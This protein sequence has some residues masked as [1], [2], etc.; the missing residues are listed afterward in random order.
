MRTAMRRELR[1]LSREIGLTI[2]YV[3]HDQIEALSLA[4]HIAIMSEGQLR[5]C[6]PTDRVYEQP[7][8]CFVARFIGEPPMNLIPGTFDGSGAFHSGSFRVSVPEV[9]AT[10]TG[11][12]FVGLRADALRL[13]QPGPDTLGATVTAVEPRGAEAIVTLDIGVET[14]A[15]TVPASSMPDAGTSVSL[16]IDAT[17]AVFFDAETEENLLF[18]GAAPARRMEAAE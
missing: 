3:T 12:G 18:P 1:R 13:A 8:H 5:Q 11:A 17:R 9:I 7:A 6:A 14:V 10:R 2:V 4:K 16:A 15:A